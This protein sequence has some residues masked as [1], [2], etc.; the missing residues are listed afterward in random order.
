MSA[1]TRKV[2]EM[3]AEGKITSDD[4]ERLLDKLAAVKE[5][6]EGEAQ[7]EGSSTSKGGQRFLRIVVT[8]DLQGHDVNMRIPL[9]FV[10]SG[11]KLVG[12]LPVGMAEKLS[13]HGFDVNAFSAMHGDELN[14]ALHDLNLDIDSDG[15]HVRIFCE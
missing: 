14:Q 3:L 11:V 15:K 12:V 6:A 8:R 2:L 5:P 13:Q 9:N 7:Q 1:E 10:R 4:A